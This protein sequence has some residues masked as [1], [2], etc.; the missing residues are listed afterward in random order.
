MG[1]IDSLKSFFT[2]PSD[3][4][5][6][7]LY[8]RCKRCG[9]PVAVRVDLRNEPSIDYE[10]NTYLLRKGVLDSKCFTLMNAELRLDANRRI[11]EQTIDK[12][13]F[14]SKAEYE[15]MTNPTSGPNQ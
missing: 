7:W 5:I 9:T 11:V 13:E 4:N 3:P 1:F 6:M 2:A 8:V 12:G 14:I 10:S 15:Q